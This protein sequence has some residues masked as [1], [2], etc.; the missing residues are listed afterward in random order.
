[1][2]VSNEIVAANA[3][4]VWRTVFRLL[5]NHADALDCYQ[6]TF[7]DAMRLDSQSVRNWRSTLCCIATRRSMDQLR[8]RYRD[9]KIESLAE[10]E[11]AISA[12]PDAGALNEELCQQVRQ[13]LTKLAPNQ[14]EAFW[15]RHV[16]ALDP[17]EIAQQ[18]NIQPGNVR[19][20]VHRAVER[21]RRI[22]GATYAV[23]TGDGESS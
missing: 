23:R 11:P 2:T 8:R 4:A 21:L 5:N 15:L 10:Y 16:E 19:V 17:V 22:F 6:Q 12:R 7:M 18:M 13:A 9:H 20:L 3:D 14:A 1:M